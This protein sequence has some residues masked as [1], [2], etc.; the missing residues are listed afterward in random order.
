MQPEDGRVV[1]NF[2]VRALRGESLVL[3]GDGSQTRSFQFVDDL[4]EGIVRLMGVEYFG[5]VNL[6]NPDEYP[7]RQ[8]AEIVARLVPTAGPIISGPLPQDDPKQRRPDNTLAGN[9]LDWKPRV[10]L[11]TGLQKTIEIFRGRVG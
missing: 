9:L 7:I 5:P 6:G 11:E 10:S 4:V 3:Y 2:I 8:F 1:T